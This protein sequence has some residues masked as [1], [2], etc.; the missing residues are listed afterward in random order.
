MTKNT[1]PADPSLTTPVALFYYDLIPTG[2]VICC[3][4]IQAERKIVRL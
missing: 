3:R 1:I 2:H 4:N